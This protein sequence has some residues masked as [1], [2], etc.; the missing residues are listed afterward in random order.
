METIGGGVILEPNPTKKKRFKVEDIE[1][2]KRKESGSSEDI[3]EMHIKKCE[4]NMM[5]VTELVK[6]TALSLEEV[7]KDVDSLKEQG[8]IKVFSMKKDSYTWHHANDKVIQEKLVGL[9]GDYHKK[10]PYRY[11]MQKAEIHMTFLK[12][13]KPNVFDLYVES[14]VEDGILKR[15]KEFLSLPDHEIKKD[16][17]YQKIENW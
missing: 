12:K 10:H 6:M 8:L 9:L 16:T 1:E 15:H 13:V 3:I 2:L 4:D 17:R 7:Q 14:L 11:G 5:S